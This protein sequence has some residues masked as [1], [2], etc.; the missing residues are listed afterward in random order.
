MADKQFLNTVYDET[1][2]QRMKDVYRDWADSYDAEVTA[3][4]YATPARAAKALAAHTST[5]TAILD[6]GCGTGLI[7]AAYADAGFKTIDGCDLSPEMLEKAKTL[8]LYRALWVSDIGLPIDTS[9][10]PYGVVSAVGVIGAGAAPLSFYDEVAN[11]V[12]PGGLFI[13]SFNDNTLKDPAFEEKVAQSTSQGEFEQ[14]H[15]DYG[16][17]LIERGMKSVLYILRRQ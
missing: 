15:R 12:R 11:L 13:F 16:P 8:G 4:G 10:G 1:G 2:V 14:V 7:G 5:D 3:N 17:H 9:G 6:V